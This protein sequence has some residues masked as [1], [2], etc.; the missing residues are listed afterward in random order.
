MANPTAP[1]QYKIVTGSGGDYAAIV[2]QDANGGIATVTTP[3]YINASGILVPAPTS[4]DG[5]PQMSLSGSNAIYNGTYNVTAGAGVIGSSQACTMVTV[6][7]D[8][9]SNGYIYV[10]SSSAQTMALAPGASRDYYVSNVD[11][12]YAKFG[13]GTTSATLNWEAKS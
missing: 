6:Q 2:Y 11:M 9:T 10:G 13:S 1:T 5:I 8:P 3:W 4:V 12:I 7:N